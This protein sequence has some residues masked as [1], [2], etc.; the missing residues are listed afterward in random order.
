MNIAWKNAC[1]NTFQK[2]LKNTVFE[3]ISKTVKSNTEE[4]VENESKFTI[5]L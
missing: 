5:L 1:L 3:V 4:E 2:S